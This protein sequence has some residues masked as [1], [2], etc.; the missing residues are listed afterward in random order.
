MNSP[1]AMPLTTIVGLAALAGLAVVPF[2]S[3]SYG[4]FLCGQMLAS[5]YVAAALQLSFAYAKILSFAQGTFFATGAYAAFFLHSAG[6]SLLPILTG[7]ALA[8][9]LLGCA[10][11]L[12]VTRMKG[13]HTA[14]IGTLL[15]AS[16]AFMSANS[17]VEITGG[18]D[19]FS[20]EGTTRLFG[21]TVAP[22]VNLVTY[23]AAFLPL[24]AYLIFAA[25]AEPTVFG[26]VMKAVGGN[27]AR[28]RQLGYDTQRRRLVVFTAAAA[29][30]GYGGAVYAFMLEHVS[31]SLF[32]PSVS[33]TAV[34]WATV[35]G[36]GTPFG[37]LLGTLVIF[38]TTELASRVFRY[39]DIAVG[40][41]LITTALYFPHGIAGALTTQN[42]KKFFGS[43]FQKRTARKR[44]F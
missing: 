27:E 7:A 38:P 9:A 35:G 17:F 32:D 28:A 16:I 24:C 44:F 33:L 13:L 22:G 34:L 2:M 37:A 3:G 20:L 31:S 14:V 1:G 11:G 36:L 42:G 30:S 39:V 25:L 41:L 15:V 4:L 29:L 5:A 18:D 6:W 8:A 40:L 26:A 10:V 19:G 21:R 12:T 43:F 23:F